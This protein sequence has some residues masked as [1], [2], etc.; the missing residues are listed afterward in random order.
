[1]QYYYVGM[2]ELVQEEVKQF[3]TYLTDK[4]EVNEIF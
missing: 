3:L 4:T 2:D 1:M